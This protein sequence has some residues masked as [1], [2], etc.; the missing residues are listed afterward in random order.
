MEH[1]P[2]QSLPRPW[3]PSQTVAADAAVIVE[4]EDVFLCRA[5]QLV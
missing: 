4:G 3:A 2:A 5:L 1:V